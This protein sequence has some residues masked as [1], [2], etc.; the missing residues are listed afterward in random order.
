MATIHLT[1]DMTDPLAVD[2]SDG[3]AAAIIHR[4]FLAVLRQHGLAG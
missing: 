3:V 2:V 4:D 1:L